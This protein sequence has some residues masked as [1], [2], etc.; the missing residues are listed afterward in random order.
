M[1]EESLF[2]RDSH[3]TEPLAARM[4]PRFL[5]EFVGQEHILGHGKLLRRAIQAD[6][7]SSLIFYGPPGTGKTTL[8]RVIANTTKSDF[9]S[10]NAVLA[11]VKDVRTSI[12]QAKNNLELYDRRTILFVDE[13]H[14]WNKAQQDALLPWVENGT[15][16][17]IGATTH[18]PFFEVNSALISRSRIF[19][20][21]QLTPDD[22]REIAG[23][24]LKDPLRGYGQMEVRIHDDALDHL[25]S[26]ADGDARGLLGA[27]QLA[28]ETTLESYPPPPGT[29]V[30]IDRAVAEDSIQRKAVLYDKEGDYHFDVISAFIKS[31]RGS[32]PDAALYWLAKMVHS[33]EDPRYIFRRML[34]SASEDVG[35]ADPG[36]L[37]VVESA[38]AAFERVG[39]PEGRFHLAHATLYLATCPKSNSTF[40]FFD[41]IKAVEFE[42]AGEVPNHLRDASR[43]KEGFGHGEGYLYPHAYAD[44]WVAQAYLPDGLRGR[45]FYQPSDQ[46]YEAQVRDRVLR[47]RELQM[48]V[49]LPDESQ[50]VLSYSR[51]GDRN[52]D[53]WLARTE[54]D[55]ARVLAALRDQVMQLARIARHHCVLLGGHYATLVLWDAMRA[56]PEGHIVALITDPR[57]YEAARHHADQ[58]HPLMR[59]MILDASS[60]PLREVIEATCA[61]TPQDDAPAV[62]G[63]Q[64]WR[65]QLAN[66]RFE[67]IVLVDPVHLNVPWTELFALLAQVGTEG[68]ELTLAQRIPRDGQRLSELVTIPDQA[69]RD[70]LAGAEEKL[71]GD[72]DKPM[73][74][75][76]ED[77]I[78]SAA[79]GTGWTWQSTETVD[80]ADHR[81][82]TASQLDH[83]LSPDRE[84]SLGS[85]IVRDAG[86]EVR[87]Q[88]AELLA[89]DLA[90]RTVAWRLRF[91]VATAR[92][93]ASESS[94]SAADP[95]GRAEPRRARSEPVPR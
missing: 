65:A 57:R 35:L 20:L 17:L 22:L 25:I 71:F 1:A 42:Q 21:K 34:I 7:I 77:T 59:P 41:A 6:M 27:L 38:A 32:D 51:S 58:A 48:E 78:T 56:A 45:L 19:Q 76:S 63:D 14:R 13:V 68:T 62:A 73:L 53:Q 88:I 69:L 95:R 4:R 26:V 39:M 36:A 80:V 90:G 8:A 16:I 15:V 82:I 37:S 50:E 29:V 86:E 72:P 28:V 75:W 94:D 2:A 74:S 44:H 87:T 9:I 46:G 43:D 40:G 67:R 30:T 31:L 70:G 5:D 3:A 64:E 92:L 10:L 61:E 85:V 11:G 24:A 12:D 33:G 89:H 84:N 55:R 79:S 18:N 52:L 66:V 91:L 93:D 54:N 49:G 60:V 81:T 83:W 47:L 23:R